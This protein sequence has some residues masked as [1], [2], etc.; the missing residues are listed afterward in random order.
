MSDKTNFHEDP[1]PL[2]DLEADA[3]P[4]KITDETVRPWLQHD[5]GDAKPHVPRCI[6]PDILATP[7]DVDIAQRLLNAY[8][9]AREQARSHQAI[10]PDIWSAIRSL[11]SNFISM[12]EKNDPEA[13]A[14]YLCN[15]SRHDATIGITQGDGEY[16]WISSST[17]YQ[18]FRALLIKDKLVSFAEAV[19]ALQCECPE[20]GPWG[21]HL[22]MDIEELFQLLQDRLGQSLVPPEV[23]G[24][25]FK[26]PVGGGHV[27]DRDLYAQFSAWIMRELLGPG[28]S[29]CE[30]GA[31]V[32]RSAFWAHRFGAHAYTILDLPHINVLQGFYLLKTLPTDRVQ[33]FCEDVP[34]PAV[35][36]W[37]HFGTSHL[38]ADEFDIV[39]SQD[40]LPEIHKDAALWYLKWAKGMGTGW[41]LSINQEAGAAYTQNFADAPTETDP[42]Q[43]VAFDLMAQVG[44]FRRMFRTPYWLRKGYVSELYRIGDR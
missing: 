31:G 34:D 33:L 38:S 41:F 21:T 8:A 17:A 16:R 18:D 12:L 3:G 9:L 40:A 43:N 22:H 15:M 36:I 44:G 19:G 14:A 1:S 13:L 6:V 10:G 39:F 2:A 26:L 28:A 27:H 30:I 42:R 37:P 35:R 23:D 20:Q 24:G 4:P 32:G 29:V 7:A 11:Q 5:T 25:L